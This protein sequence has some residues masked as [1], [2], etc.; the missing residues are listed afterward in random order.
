MGMCKSR[1]SKVK[2]ERL[3]EHFVVTTTTRYAAELIGVNRRCG[4]AE[5]MG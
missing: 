1:I 3:L 2:Q 4:T 5:C